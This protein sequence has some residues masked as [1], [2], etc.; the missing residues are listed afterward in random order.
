MGY[1][2]TAT[3]LGIPKGTLEQYTKYHTKSP[4]ALGIISKFFNLYRTELEKMNHQSHSLYNGRRNWY[5]CCAAQ[6]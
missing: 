5:N 1:K 4:E 6:A 3:Y 2:W